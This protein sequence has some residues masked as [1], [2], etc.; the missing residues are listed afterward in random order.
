[1]YIIRLQWLLTMPNPSFKWNTLKRAPLGALAFTMNKL[2]LSICLMIGFYSLAHGEALSPDQTIKS[3]FQSVHT[4][5]TNAMDQVAD[6][7]RIASH[8]RHAMS[9]ARLVEFLRGIDVTKIEFAKRVT[10]GFPQS[11]TVR[12]TKPLS[13][14]FDLELRKE[15]PERQEDH[16]VIVALHP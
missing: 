1:M 5:D 7:D 15:T 8:K 2:L 14:D 6:F 12:M 11:V 4:G 13:Y 16:Y 9:R 10:T 3:L